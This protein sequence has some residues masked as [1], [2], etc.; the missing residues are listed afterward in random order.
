MV[1][2]QPFTT[3]TTVGDYDV[4]L[5][6]EIASGEYKIRVGLF[7]DEE[8]FGCSGTFEIVS[9]DDDVYSYTFETFDGS[10]WR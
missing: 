3:P 7:E 6:E 2:Q 10:D 8:L 9:D 5:P 4:V 1:R